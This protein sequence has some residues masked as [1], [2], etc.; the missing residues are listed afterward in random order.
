[1]VPRFDHWPGLGPAVPNTTTVPAMLARPTPSS[2]LPPMTTN[3]R[4]MQAPASAPAEPRTMSS[5]PSYRA[6]RPR[7][8]RRLEGRRCPLCRRGRPPFRGR[9]PSR[10]CPS[11]R[12]ATA[13]PGRHTGPDVAL[14][15]D[16]AVGELRADALEPGEIADQPDPGGPLAGDR[17]EVANGGWP[18]PATR[19]GNREMALAGRSAHGWSSRADA[20]TAACGGVFRV[21]TTSS[22][23]R[24]PRRS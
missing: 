11:P 12:C 8:R 5:P 6:S 18:D 22:L 4:R 17:E 7:P 13:H 3:P 1:M 9:P 24:Q 14:D 15:D 2:A 20:S 16:L 21:S 19:R 10:R 23:T